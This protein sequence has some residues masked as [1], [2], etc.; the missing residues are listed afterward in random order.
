MTAAAIAPGK[1]AASYNPSTQRHSWTKDAEHH[2][3][4]DFC[5][6]HVENREIAGVDRWYQA[7]TWPEAL[8]LDDGHN[9]YR[10]TV[11]KCPGPPA[12]SAPAAAAPAGIVCKGCGDQLLAYVPTDDGLPVAIEAKDPDGDLLV[13]EGRNGWT[14]RLLNL[15]PV[16]NPDPERRRRRHWCVYKYGCSGKAGL[17]PNRGR[18]YAVGTWC[19]DCA[20][21]NRR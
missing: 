13:V 14:V 4:C 2:K 5:G 11:P 19:D 20:P 16:A 21:G 15:H 9:R 7:W 3:T 17:C 1:R 12:S 18:L 8:G 6:L 10:G